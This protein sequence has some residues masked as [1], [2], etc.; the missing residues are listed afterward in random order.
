LDGNR[1]GWGLEGRGVIVTGAAQGIG[2]ATVRAFADVGARV[3]AVDLREEQV[4]AVVESLPGGPHQAAAIDLN[5]LDAHAG[6]VQ[7][8]VDALG[9]LHAI[10]LAAGVLKREPFD[11][12]SEEAWDWQLDTNLKATFFL[13]RTAGDQMLKDGVKGSI[14]TFTSISGTMGGVSSAPAYTASKG[15]VISLTY[16]M[17]RHYGPLGIRVNSIAPGFVDTPMQR[18]GFSP[19]AQAYIDSTPLARQADPAEVG[20]VAVFLA[21]DHA[22]F[23]TGAIMN[24][25]G[26]GWMG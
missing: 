12:V 11:D 7:G 2:E 8:A 20:S 13:S 4:R 9:S 26:G 23:V 17:A 18:A 1:Q 14:C 22:S 19:A 25:S 15:G 6:L 5:D 10:V 3:C 24:V 21:S 16:A